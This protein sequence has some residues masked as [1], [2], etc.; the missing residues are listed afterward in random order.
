[1]S[2]KTGGDVCWTLM[3]RSWAA[4]GNLGCLGCFSLSPFAIEPSWSKPEGPLD[5]CARLLNSA[6]LWHRA[7]VSKADETRLPGT[8]MTSV[9][10]IAWK[11]EHW[12]LHV[13]QGLY[14]KEC[15]YL[16]TSMMTYSGCE[17][18]RKSSALLHTLEISAAETVWGIFSLLSL[19]A[20]KTVRH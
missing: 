18:T 8:F 7:T 15:R 1:M 14:L 9:I 3:Q 20:K 17:H 16:W 6:W 19:R 13:V 10:M 4:G 12:L 11:N 5:T 2:I